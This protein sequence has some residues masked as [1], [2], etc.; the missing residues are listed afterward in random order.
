MMMQ[1]FDY[2]TA[3]CLNKKHRREYLC[4]VSLLKSQQKQHTND[5]QSITDVFRIIS[6]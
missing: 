1:Y 3:R 6:Y 4:G 5:Q 2:L